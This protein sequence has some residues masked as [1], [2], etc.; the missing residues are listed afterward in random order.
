M[1]EY[2]YIY[3]MVGKSPSY[4]NRAIKCLRVTSC[5]THLVFRSCDDYLF[6]FIDGSGCGLYQVEFTEYFAIGLSRGLAHPYGLRQLRIRHVQFRR[7]RAPSQFLLPDEEPH[8]CFDSGA[9][10]YQKLNYNYKISLF[11]FSFSW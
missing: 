2:S 9:P 4:W 8:V 7:P 5:S 3:Y 6:S 1:R 10:A 11:F